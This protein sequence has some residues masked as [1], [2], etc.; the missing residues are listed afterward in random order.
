M[1]RQLVAAAPGKLEWRELPLPQ[2]G[3]D[4]VLV[5]SRYGAV[6]QGTEFSMVKG[7][8][9]RRGP[10]NEELRLHDRKA[11]VLDAMGLE[12]MAVDAMG[13]DAMAVQAP[14]GG[15][16]T[17][18]GSSPRSDTSD[19]VP[20]PVG[21]MVSGTVVTVGREAAGFEPGDQVFGYAPCSE[22]IKIKQDRLWQLSGGDWKSALCLDPARFAMAA[23]RDGGIRLGDTA[24]V[25]GLGAIG[26][27]SVRMAKLSGA[28]LVYGIDPVESRRSL[29]LQ[30]G[31]DDVFSPEEWDVG[32]EL[33]LRTGG[34]GVDVAVE[35]SG[36]AAALQ[37]CLRG[38]AFGG[39]V[40]CGAFP[41]PYPPGLD[42]GAEAH[43]NC[44][45]I[46]FSRAASDPNREHPRWCSD[47]IETECRLLIDAGLIDGSGIIDRVVPYDEFKREYEMVMADPA[48]TIKLGIVFPAAGGPLAERQHG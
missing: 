16:E 5:R 8:A 31:A 9:S 12:T 1:N 45:T 6:K 14:S 13:M 29:A 46:L 40:V 22:Y 11:M 28:R 19:W 37:E 15:S 23:V 2:P 38:T 30:M 33:K 24:A 18:A 36:S 26:L 39:T 10:W 17:S 4:E 42:F 44:L 7:T 41:A 43:M 47:R 25:F 34:T 20:F 48:R 35:L 32:R 3:P 27:I 21:N